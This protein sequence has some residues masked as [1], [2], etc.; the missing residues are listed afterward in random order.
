MKIWMKVGRALRR[1]EYWWIGLRVS[2]RRKIVLSV[3]WIILGGIAGGFIGKECG[4][5][6]AEKQYKIEMSKE[7]KER[8]Q[9]KEELEEEIR[10]LQKRLREEQNGPQLENLPWQLTLVN[11]NYPMKKN[12]AP[13]LTEI[14]QGYSVDS[15]IAKPLREMLEAAEKEGLNIIFCSAYRS[16]KRQE[17]VFNESMRDRVNQGMGYWEAYQETSQSVAIP[18]TSEHGLGL[19]VD[20]IS[21]QY[22]ELDEKQAKTKEA[23]WL[24][25]NCHK[26][27]FI[28]RY[29]PEKTYETG[30]IFEP[31]HY[32]YVGVEHATEIMRRGITL[33][34]YLG[35]YKE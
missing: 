3:I 35:E 9:E 29:P 8:K 23:K 33:E 1:I 32:R 26:Y 7:T 6:S 22:T 21:N 18:G 19:A 16:V 25:E 14:E 12:Y 24:K 28:L 17:Q 31:W 15:R 4:K 34:T 20:L 11:E 5:K 30:I 2:T 13:K 27:G 10:L